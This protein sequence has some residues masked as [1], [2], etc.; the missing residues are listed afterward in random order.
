MDVRAVGENGGG[1]DNF[2]CLQTMWRSCGTYIFN[3]FRQDESVHSYFE[4]CSEFL[5]AKSADA[6]RQELS[7]ATQAGLRHT[8]A[9]RQ[10]FAAFPFAESG[11]VQGFM[12]RFA[13]ENYYL[14]RDEED[15]ELQ[16]YLTCLIAY[17]REHGKTP[18]AKCCR[19]GL[20]A[21]W[22]DRVLSPI[23][24]Y[25]VRNPDAMFRSYWSFGG[26]RSYFL[27]ASLLIVSKNRHLELFREL[28]DELR[29]PPIADAPLRREFAAARE[30]SL[31]LDHQDFRDLVLFLW[32]ITLAQNWCVAG[33]LVDVDLLA[34]SDPYR[35]SVADQLYTQTGR[36]LSLHDAELRQTPDAPGR[37]L[38]QRGA[39]CAVNAMRRLLRG[40]TLPPLELSA[41]SASV[42]SALV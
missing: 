26:R 32:A 22:L 39:S 8:G 29:I 12:K 14:K 6:I 25:V 2:I 7:D 38:S 10:S 18:V 24:I 20:R 21:D 1:Q 34:Y 17:A 42:L 41:Q 36:R 35:R 23:S 15:P 30:A 19:F 31:R 13:F 28:A 3:K 11:G 27:V 16:R 40:Q 4:P 5:V 33:V 9:S 37:L